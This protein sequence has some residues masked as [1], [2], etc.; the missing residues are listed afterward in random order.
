MYSSSVTVEPPVQQHADR[1]P[2]SAGEL[3]VEEFHPVVGQHANP[4]T[5]PDPERGQV[6]SRRVDAAVEVGV[7][8]AAVAVPSSRTASFVGALPG[9]LRDPVIGAHRPVAYWSG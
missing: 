8:E 9:V 4:V 5:P 3:D 6:G 1:A 2:A 7:A